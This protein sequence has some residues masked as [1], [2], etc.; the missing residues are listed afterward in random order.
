MIMTK[1]EKLAVI[2]NAAIS[3]NDTGSCQVQIALI[4][5]R[6]ACIS[7]H[8]KKFPKDRHSHFGLVKL[9]GRRRAFAK[10]LARN[11]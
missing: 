4:D 9:L 3:P 10:Y 6:V 7:E 8:L 1:E 5:K 11:A 2:K